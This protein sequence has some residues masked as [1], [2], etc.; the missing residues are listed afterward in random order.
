MSNFGVAQRSHKAPQPLTKSDW[1]VMAVCLKADP[2]LFHPEA[3]QVGRKGR[4]AK[5]RLR[6]AEEQAKRI[7]HTC[8][9]RS[10]CLQYAL[11]HHEHGIWGG[12]T[13]DERA[14]VKRQRAVRRVPA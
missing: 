6:D 5:Q 13:E 11:D 4:G 10:A 2:E 8:P 1:Q 7:C 3:E 12:L 9:V 14:E